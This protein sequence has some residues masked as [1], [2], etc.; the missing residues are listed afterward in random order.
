MPVHARVLGIAQ[1]AGVPQLGCAC[2]NCAHY[3]DTPLLPAA[4]GIRAER[5]YLIDAT[6]A[7]GAQVRRLGAVPD[8]ILLTHT[9][10]GH[11]AGLLQLGEEGLDARGIE[12]FGTPLVCSM[13]ERNEPWRRLVQRGNI[14]LVVEN[15]GTSLAFEDGLTV[16]SFPVDHRDLETVGYLVSGPERTLLY[17]PDI[18]EW[19]L[20]LSALL[21]RCDV[22]L[23]D[24]TFYA[25]DE[26]GRQGD[27]PHPAITDTL[28]RLT[29]AE[30]AKVRF[31]HMNHTNRALAPDGP[32]A[33]L[34][35]PN[36]IFAL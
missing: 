35:H 6:P 11:I 18:D 9:H 15:A 12:V 36:E 22:A 19:N 29:D 17:L 30:R 28:A 32:K 5:T 13:L 34:A 2:A 23:L 16:E 20:D 8:V 7:I 33:P 26:L 31:I 21:A 4:L 24:G 3:T 10:T 1:D 25:A 14:R 27:V